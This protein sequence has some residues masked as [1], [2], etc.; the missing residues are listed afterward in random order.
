DAGSREKGQHQVQGSMH[1]VAIRDDAGRGYH[2]DGREHVEQR[3]FK[4]HNGPQ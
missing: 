3:S 4:F 2:E 1:R